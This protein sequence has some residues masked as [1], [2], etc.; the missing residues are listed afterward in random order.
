MNL[1]CGPL[2][3]LLLMLLL[4]GTCLQSAAA[5]YRGVEVGQRADYL[6]PEF[7]EVARGEYEARFDNELL[8]VFSS[9]ALVQGFK[10]IPLAPMTLAEA[11]AA[12][13]PDLGTNDL[14][15]LLNFN[16]VFLALGDARNRVAYFAQSVRPESIVRA[17]GYYN[18]QTAAMTFTAA[19]SSPEAE[20]LIAAARASSANALNERPE[21]TDP[22]RQASFVV[23]QATEASRTEAERA[24]AQLR[25]Y[26]RLCT[27]TPECEARRREQGFEVVTAAS[28]FLV[29]LMR[30]ER[31]Y[32]AN[33]NLIGEKP[34]ELTELQ[35]LSDDIVQQVRSS[36]GPVQFSRR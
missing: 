11:L 13:S 18:D 22:L 2:H 5:D 14:R 24:L 6:P 17:I 4:V 33:A 23:T 19:V 12:H 25:T 20:E 32:Q 35:Q 29:Y 30:A 15:L 27:G 16:G 7:D 34:L 26:K 10:V 9:G 1:K 8:Q 36:V 28:R 31:A 3:A 21:I